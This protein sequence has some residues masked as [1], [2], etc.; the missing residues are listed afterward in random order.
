MSSKQS[1]SIPRD[2]S[3]DTIGTY[4]EIEIEESRRYDEED[5]VS[6]DEGSDA[7]SDEEFYMN[8]EG[9]SK[10]IKGKGV[11]HSNGTADT[12]PAQDRTKTEKK[13]R[14][15][16]DIDLSLVVALVSPIGNWLTG[17]DHVKNLFLILLLIFYLHQTV[18]GT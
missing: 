10:D 14:S 5:S 3:A 18:E 13:A 6:D 12:P 4:S 2:E 7:E 16:S 17:S 1:S 8:D 15:W 9:S 11:A